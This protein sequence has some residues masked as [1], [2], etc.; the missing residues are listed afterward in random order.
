MAFRLT[1]EHERRIKVLSRS[2]NCSRGQAIRD[3][4][5]FYYR[6]VVRP[7]S[8]IYMPSDWVDEPSDLLTELLPKHAG[9]VEFN[10]LQMDILDS[11]LPEM[12]N[13]I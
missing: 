10:Q 7:A 2:K 11:E 1:G 8:T 4:I 3:A 6:F 9:I 12:P 5:D 13:R